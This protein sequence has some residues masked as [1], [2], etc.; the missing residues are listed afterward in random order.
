MIERCTTDTSGRSTGQTGYHTLA[1]TVRHLPKGRDYFVASYR[2]AF[3][4]TELE[5]CSAA[6]D[7]HQPLR[8]YVALYILH[9]WPP[10][11]WVK[12]VGGGT[13]AD[14]NGNIPLYHEAVGIVAFVGQP[15]SGIAGI[16][17]GHLW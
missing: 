17:A 6:A 7:R 14:K 16:A 3:A 12:G 11:R 2:A 13:F 15:M 1:G 4:R 10:S 5:V 8:K 9:H